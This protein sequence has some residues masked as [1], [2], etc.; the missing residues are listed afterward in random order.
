[1]KI[2]LK[3]HKAIKKNSMSNTVKYML[4]YI[5]QTERIE[6]KYKS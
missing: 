1:M 2:F 5:H 3:V 6:L 4:K